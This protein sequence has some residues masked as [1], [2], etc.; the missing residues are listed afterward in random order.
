[1]VQVP[2]SLLHW[3]RKANIAF[4]VVCLNPAP[5]NLPGEWYRTRALWFIFPSV[6]NRQTG[7]CRDLFPSGQLDKLDLSRS[8]SCFLKSIPKIKTPASIRYTF[9][10]IS[11]RNIPNTWTNRSLSYIVGGPS[12]SYTENVYLMR[13]RY[14]VLGILSEISPIC[15]FVLWYTV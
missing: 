5:V 3:T 13:V 12:T 11:H 7:I 8:R 6:A 9:F 1:M 14:A 15:Q 10:E 4:L 2:L